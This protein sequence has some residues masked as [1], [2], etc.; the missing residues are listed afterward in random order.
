MC[1][2]VDTVDEIKFFLHKCTCIV[3]PNKEATALTVG[4]CSCYQRKEDAAATQSG[5][6]LLFLLCLFCPQVGVAIGL[7][8]LI[9]SEAC[10]GTECGRLGPIAAVMWVIDSH[11]A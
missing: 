10:E 1:K 5:F 6:V 11:Q 8:F 9:I 3:H 4:A 7:N 2:E